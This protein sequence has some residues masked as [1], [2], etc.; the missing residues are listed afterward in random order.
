MEH[1]LLVGT[2]HRLLPVQAREALAL[3]TDQLPVHLQELN[4]HLS[5]VVLLSTCNRIELYGATPDV[6]AGESRLVDFLVGLGAP[7]DCL[8]AAQDRGAIAHLFAVAAGLDSMILGEYEILGQVRTAY[9]TA[10]ACQTVGSQ[11]EALF[12]SAIHV[13]KRARSETAIGR[14]AASAA[15]AAV[16]LARQ[17]FGELYERRVL[18]IGAGEMGQRV[19]KNL[20][21]QGAS[22]IIVANRTFDRAVALARELGGTA[23]HFD[24]LADALV[25]A[26]VVISATGA[27]HVILNA[28]TISRAMAL[29]SR[30]P[31][32]II[33]I[34]VPRDV[35][36]AARLVPDVHVF[37]LDALQ[38]VTEQSM[39][40]REKEAARVRAIVEAEV[41][42]F[43]SRQGA[44]SVSPVIRALRERAEAIRRGELARTLPRLGHL[45]EHEREIID[46]MTR[47]MLRKFLA[48]PTMHLK[49]ASQEDDAQHY[50]DALRDLFDLDETEAPYVSNRIDRERI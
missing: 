5:E 7:A 20:R 9:Q 28:E 29:R 40:E 6:A 10:R 35:D 42:E 34:A 49:H 36:P 22:T 39:A 21:A 50:V 14:G 26:D 48:A 18:V 24:A 33:D 4:K 47:S 44:R 41:E 46:A 31:L 8:R 37:D 19:A 25:Q 30:R 11:L 12:Q 15:Y 38:L 1:I 17:Q 43:L 16:Q 27:P 13:G 45:N 3:S 23:V 32:C 2:N